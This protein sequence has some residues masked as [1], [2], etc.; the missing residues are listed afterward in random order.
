MLPLLA[1]LRPLSL[2]APN[3]E[4]YQSAPSQIRE[5]IHNQFCYFSYAV[6]GIQDDRVELLASL[7][8]LPRQQAL[9]W[10]IGSNVRYLSAP[11]IE[12]PVQVHTMN[13]FQQTP[14]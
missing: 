8:E 12:W 6:G 10:T 1:L 3:A 14:P 9:D 7:C 4:T 11:T 5:M 13:E 2:S